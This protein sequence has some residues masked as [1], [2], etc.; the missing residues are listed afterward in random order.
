MAWASRGRAQ[1][2]AT[3][4]T[5]PGHAPPPWAPPGIRA[6]CSCCCW[7][8]RRGALSSEQPRSGDPKAPQACEEERKV[9]RDSVLEPGTGSPNQA[10]PAG[11]AGQGGEGV[12]PC[13]VDP[14]TS[15][16]FRE[17]HEP[18]EAPRGGR[19]LPGMPQGQRRLLLAG[20]SKLGHHG[21][22]SFCEA[23]TFLCV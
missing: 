6:A 4:T 20:H 10:N 16:F 1:Q 23:P 22:T 9:G 11:K 7:S 15:A 8:Q 18:A 3:P 21:V 13:G 2:L 12:L 5:R 14:G 19:D 17:T